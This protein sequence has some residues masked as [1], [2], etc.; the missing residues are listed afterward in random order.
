MNG[1]TQKIRN[2]VEGGKLGV[3]MLRSGDAS[4]RAHSPWWVERTPV[5]IFVDRIPSFP[6]S[7]P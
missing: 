4:L 5:F 3:G 1:T 7:L 2:P 6:G